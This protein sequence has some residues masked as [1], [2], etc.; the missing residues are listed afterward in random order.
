MTDLNITYGTPTMINLSIIDLLLRNGK[1]FA[2][3][4]DVTYM[5]K[6]KS[7]NAD[8]DT[9]MSKDLKTATGITLDAPNE[10]IKIS[11]LP[12]DF[13]SDKLRPGKF[14]IC[15]AVEFDDSGYYIED[16]DPK[17]ERFIEV[18]PDKTRK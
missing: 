8:D 2:D 5:V 10:I 9:L 14:L 6:K 11:V 15:V 7:F 1:P 3:I 13:G 17:L 16:E 18:S 12:E 4:T